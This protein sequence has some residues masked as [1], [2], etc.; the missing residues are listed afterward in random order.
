MEISAARLHSS[1]R[2]YFSDQRHLV[3]YGCDPLKPITS[4]LN[5]E[6]ASSSS[7]SVCAAAKPTITPITPCNSCSSIALELALIKELADLKVQVKMKKKQLRAV[8]KERKK[9]LKQNGPKS[10]NRFS[11]SSS[12]ASSDQEREATMNMKH[13][14]QG[15]SQLL[16]DKQCAFVESKQCTLNASAERN[17]SERLGSYEMSVQTWKEDALRG[18]VE[19]TCA[20]RIEVCVGGKCKKAGSEKLLSSM[21]VHLGRNKLVEAV[22]CKCMGRCA[23]AMNLKVMK[24]D[25]NPQH[26][27]HASVDDAGL[28]LRHHFGLGPPPSVLPVCPPSS[29]HPI[30]EVHN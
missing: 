12:S 21:R 13:L 17:S 10:K 11:S 30:P 1:F 29:T 28:I 9:A 22:G 23:L 6:P 25:T 4:L 26:H 16:A 27:S 18:A 3:F 2:P 7:T 8:A 5:P 14:K 24:E 15:I 19:A 20:G